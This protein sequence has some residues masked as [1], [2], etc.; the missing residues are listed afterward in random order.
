MVMREERREKR[1]RREKEKGNGARARNNRILGEQTNVTTSLCLSLAS[2]KHEA[3]PRCR[4]DG[5]P[6]L[7][8]SLIFPVR[9]LLFVFRCVFRAVENSFP[10]IFPDSLAIFL[11]FYIFKCP[12]RE[13]ERT[14]RNKEE[15][16][17]E[18]PLPSLSF[19]SAFARLRA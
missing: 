11:S 2:P 13:G 17:T 16:E 1:K 14:T 18:T 12:P 5:A 19:F 6:P 4:G 7:F 10:S 9:F 8:G 3:P 15:R